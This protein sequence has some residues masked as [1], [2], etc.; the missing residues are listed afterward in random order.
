M[1][2][3]RRISTAEYAKLI[4]P[5]AVLFVLGLALVSVPDNQ[6]LSALMH[7]A[8]DALMITGALA[9]TVE[10]F[11]LN[12]LVRHVADDI[13]FRLVGG[14][15]PK[16]FRRT[17]WNVIK[18]SDVREHWRKEYTIK[19]LPDGK[20]QV[21]I[22]ESYAVKNYSDATIKYAPINA[23][24]TFWDPVITHVEYRLAQS[25]GYAFGTSD[26]A[27]YT[28]TDPASKVQTV[29]KLPAIRLKPI[30][31]DPEAICTVTWHSTLTTPEDYTDTTSFA[32]P[33]VGLTIQQGD[34]PEDMTFVVCEGANIQHV[35]GSKTWEFDEGF[36]NGQYVRVWWFKKHQ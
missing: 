15:L 6:A 31:E 33:T 20:V 23:N 12:R 25:T 28:T 24:E 29:G 35:P 2:E 10:L 11:T 9:I 5:F 18:T 32:G 36:I 17:L 22:K 7:K 27:K 16:A 1:V 21:D 4:T 3:F 30:R 19:G 8:G 13:A 26:L 34:I 14:H